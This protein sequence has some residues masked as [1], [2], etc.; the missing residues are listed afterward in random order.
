ML[1]E[2]RKPLLREAKQ[3]PALLTDL[4][5]LEE[6]V[7]ESYT[8]R[9]FIELLQNADDAGA[10]RFH[11]EKV[12]HTLIVANDGRIF[13][14][15]DLETLCRSAA[16]RKH[17]GETIGYRGI[18]FKSVVSFARKVHLISGELMVTFSRELTKQ[19]IPEA[20]KVPLVRIPHPIEKEVFNI[21]KTPLQKLHSDGYR[22][23]FAFD[24]TVSMAIETEFNSFDPT[25]LLFLRNVRE[26]EFGEEKPSV[27]KIFRSDTKESLENLKLSYDGVEKDWQLHHIDDVA[28]AFEA[29]SKGVKR[30]KEQDSL[31]HAFLPT[32]EQTGF[33]IKI[34]GDV[35]T[36]PSRS[37]IVLDERT[38]NC[39]QKSAKYIVSLI[40]DSVEEIKTKSKA[41]QILTALLPRADVRLIDFQRPSFEKELV[42][43]VIQNGK[44]KLNGLI[45]RPIWLKSKKAFE[46]IAQDAG[47]K[48]LPVEFEEIEGL[49]G[50]LK[51][52]G[53]KEAT[54]NEFSSAL[55]KAHFS[56]D[57]AADIVLHLLSLYT[58]G[59]IARNESMVGW[60]IW[61]V[62]NHVLSLEDA[63]SVK[64]PLRQEFLDLVRER[65]GNLHVFRR[66]L[67]EIADESIA[68]CLL[69][70]A[71]TPDGIEKPPKVNKSAQ[72]KFGLKFDHKNIHL[73]KWRSAE[74]QVL[75]L[76]I[77]AGWHVSDVSKQN[78]GYDLE[79]YNS[80]GEQVYIEVKSLGRIGEPF[81]MTSN[82]QAVARDLSYSYYIAL[83]HQMGNELMVSLICDPLSKLQMTRQCRQWVWVCENYPFDP[84]RIDLL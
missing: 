11:I 48:Y 80:N 24:Q 8:A 58:T 61:P 55:P 83:V 51:A 33:G 20:Q 70:E 78:L 15:E 41:C 16:S 44:Q 12:G 53:A 49:T 62:G 54:I 29:T 56:I 50:F 59:Q 17:R 6:Y 45:L 30:L 19:E 42:Q 38:L 72:E 18:G 82:E 1:E 13:T 2:V 57:A 21:L 31:V 79:G 66:F 64:S 68:D 77:E 39:I 81:F 28:I 4:A 37:S 35:S 14:S 63:A 47:F 23:I 25:S 74:Q 9:S 75:Q 27:F 67:Y 73:K 10:H 22:T 69:K 43:S 52:M 5:G 36:D 40:V 71:E 60:K 32:K 7:A 46:K 26:I 3:S 76:L 34:N 65:E 84:E